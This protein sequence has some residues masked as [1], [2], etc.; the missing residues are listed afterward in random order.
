MEVRI[1]MRESLEK[2]MLSAAL[3]GITI[4]HIDESG[5]VVLSET[6]KGTET[7][8][9]WSR[10]RGNGKVVLMNKG[11]EASPDLLN[12]GRVLVEI[13]KRQKLLPTDVR[14]LD[15]YGVP[16]FDTGNIC[17]FCEKV[18]DWAKDNL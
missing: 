10:W 16:K 7:D 11:K 8:D 18:W 3:D 12:M 14:M 13:D 1:V 9:A 2:I 6:H 15:S 5:N 4:H 17:S